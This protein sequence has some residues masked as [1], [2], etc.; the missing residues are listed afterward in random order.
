MGEL[1]NK[2]VQIY[3]GDS[4]KKEGILKDI[5]QSGCTFLITKSESEDFTVGKLHFISYSAN[6]SFCEI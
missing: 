6:L 2:T 1:L 3:P 4:K 5:N